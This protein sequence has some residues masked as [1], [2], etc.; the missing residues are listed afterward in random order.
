M[1]KTPPNNSK[2]LLFG[3]IGLLVNLI[4]I[5]KDALAF[6]CRF[7]LNMTQIKQSLAV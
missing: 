7:I 2:M 3:Q 1:F 5:I 6:E 4:S